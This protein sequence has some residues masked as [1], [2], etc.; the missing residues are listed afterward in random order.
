MLRNRIVTSVAFMSAVSGVILMMYISRNAS[1]STP[2]FIYRLPDGYKG[3]FMIGV[4]S[5]GTDP[6][7]E[8]GRFTYI[9]P[10]AGVLFVRSRA[11]LES[12]HTEE[13][14]FMSR[15]NI[16]IDGFTSVPPGET[17][18]FNLGTDQAG[19]TSFL[20]GTRS[21]YDHVRSLLPTFESGFTLRP[22]PLTLDRSQE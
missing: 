13:A 15:G 16:P 22:G 12:P 1:C 14:H 2:H 19:T 21:D 8:N 10:P 5:S 6:E 20:L 11:P 17:G 3:I 4:S 7:S 9:I 18:I